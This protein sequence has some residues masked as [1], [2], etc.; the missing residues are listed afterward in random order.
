MAYIHTAHAACS[1]M[2]GS[3]CPQR[4]AGFIA[5]ALIGEFVSALLVTTP[6]CIT[7]VILYIWIYHHIMGSQQMHQIHRY[8]I[9]GMYAI[10]LLGI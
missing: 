5:M 7:I 2:Q 1:I 6:I 4:F 3:I 8:I 10:I 9:K